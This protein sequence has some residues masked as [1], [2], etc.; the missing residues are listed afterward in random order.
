MKHLTL[1]CLGKLKE[2]HWQ[3]AEADYRKRLSPYFKIQILELRE[4]IASYNPE[5]SGFQWA[6]SD[7]PR[8]QLEP[9]GYRGYIEGRPVRQINAPAGPYNY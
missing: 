8:F 5:I 4:V 6:D 3:E 2:K 7:G 1:V 9:V